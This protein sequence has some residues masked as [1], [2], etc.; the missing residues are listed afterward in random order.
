MNKVFQKVCNILSTVILAIMIVIAAVLLVPYAFGYQTLAVLSG[1]MEPAYPVGS[2]VFVKKLAPQEVHVGDAITFQLN[3][4]TVATHRVV[5]IDTEKH[6]FITKGDANNTED[7]PTDFNN[8]VGRAATT[9]IP[10]LGYLSVNIKTPAGIMACTGV[11]MIIL[12]LV[13][14]PEIVQSKPKTTPAIQES[15]DSKI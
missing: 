3:E 8:L 13:F 5:K 4:N 12:L 9:A 15:E 14:L 7:G 1:S 10:Y 6:Q 2:V 11:V